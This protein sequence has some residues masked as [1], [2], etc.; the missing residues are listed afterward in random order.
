[1]NWPSSRISIAS[2]ANPGGSRR[3]KLTCQAGEVVN[4]SSVSQLTAPGDG[5]QFRPTS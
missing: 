5:V 2:S 3:R 4:G 1:M